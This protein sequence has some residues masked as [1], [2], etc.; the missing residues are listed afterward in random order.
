M[1]ACLVFPTIDLK[2]GQVESLLLY[3]VQHIQSSLTWSA[4]ETAKKLRGVKALFTKITWN[5]Y[6]QK[7]PQDTRYGGWSPFTSNIVQPGCR[8]R[9]ASKLD[10]IVSAPS[11]L[12]SSVSTMASEI[13]I[14]ACV[15]LLIRLPRLYCSTDFAPVNQF[16]KARTQFDSSTCF[17]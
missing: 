10:I 3:V 8:L 1:C 15:K 2:F 7:H 12:W 14:S 4:I 17:F 11:S 16:L 5:I 6:W 9:G 13:W